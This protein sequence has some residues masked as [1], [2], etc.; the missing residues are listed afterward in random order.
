MGM[1]IDMR[2][3][4]ETSDNTRWISAMAYALAMARLGGRKYKVCSYD[5]HGGRGWSA[6]PMEEACDAVR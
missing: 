3:M 2:L 1:E 5:G 4:A 6:R